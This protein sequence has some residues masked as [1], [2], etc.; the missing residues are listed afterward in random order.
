L[1]ADPR[2]NPAAH[3]NNAILVASEKGCDSVVKLLLADPRVNPTANDDEAIRMAS[4]EGHDLVVKLLLADPRVN[5]AAQD[6]HA[7][8]IASQRGHDSVLKLLLPDPRVDVQYPMIGFALWISAMPVLDKNEFIIGTFLDVS[9]PQYLIRFIA[10]PI[11]FT[12]EKPYSIN[13]FI[14]YTEYLHRVFCVISKMI[15]TST[16][17]G[18]APRQAS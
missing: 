9:V 18:I 15:Q 12:D 8:K 6:N 1:L 3:D 2:V 11:E 5:P 4:Q 13:A 16:V 7:V 14:S 10:T 17:I